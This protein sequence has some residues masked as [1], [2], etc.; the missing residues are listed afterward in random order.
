MEEKVINFDTAKAAK[1]KGFD[2]DCR[3]YFSNKEERDSFTEKASPGNYNSSYWSKQDFDDEEWISRPAQALLQKWLREVH[4]IHINID[5]W[6]K[7]TFHLLHDKD[8]KGS[9][10]PKNPSQ[11]NTYEEALEIALQESLKLI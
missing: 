5:C 1:E 4:N 10:Y 8:S 9:F 7:A 3:F 6:K 2:W 11:W